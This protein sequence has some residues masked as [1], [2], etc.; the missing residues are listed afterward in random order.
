VPRLGVAPALQ[1]VE[2]LPDSLEHLLRGERGGPRCGKLHRE[3][4]VVERPAEGHCGVTV[5]LDPGTLPEKSV[6][7][8]PSDSGSSANSTSPRTRSSS[9]LVTSN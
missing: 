6:T 2:P 4:E 9:R 5:L 3:R 1:E 7:A 8:S